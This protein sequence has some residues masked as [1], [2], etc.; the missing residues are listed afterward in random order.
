MF[1]V[2][3]PSVKANWRL[4]KGANDE[5]KLEDFRNICYSDADFFITRRFVDS[6]GSTTTWFCRSVD[7]RVLSS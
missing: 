4:Q 2:I 3:L 6:A 1:Y 7:F 5:D